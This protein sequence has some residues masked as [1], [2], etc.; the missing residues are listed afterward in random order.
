MRELLTK[1]KAFTLIE[2]LVVIGIVMLLSFAAINGYLDY[3]KNALLGLAGDDVLSQINQQKTQT[4]YGKTS[5]ID[6]GVKCYGLLFEDSEIYLFNQGFESKKEFSEGEWEYVG[7]GELDTNNSKK[8]EMDEMVSVLELI[9]DDVVYDRFAIRF[10][11]TA[12]DVTLF[13]DDFSEINLNTLYEKQ[14]AITLQYGDLSD[15]QQ[16]FN[17]NF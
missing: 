10:F 5:N 9:L 7:C 6:E 17:Y 12:G 15:Y 14:L 3:R 2:L 1:K 4:I 11:P 8:L 16:T 13:R